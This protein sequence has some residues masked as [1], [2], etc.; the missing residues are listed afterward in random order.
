MKIRI[1]SCAKSS[2]EMR[3]SMNKKSSLILLSILHICV[4]GICVLTI[5]ANRDRASE[6]MVAHVSSDTEFIAPQTEASAETDP[7]AG[8]D[9]EPGTETDPDKG[10]DAGT[11]SEADSVTGTETDP[12][13]GSDPETE[14]APDADAGEDGEENSPLYSFHYTGKKANL[15]IRSAPS[16]EEMI[17]GKIPVGGNGSI[18]ELTNDKWALVEYQGIVGY[19][20]RD[21]LE[22]HEIEQ[23]PD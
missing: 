6:V 14:P 20:S 19:C 1:F 23:S 9:A 5:Y 4:L 17:I 16:L 7:G 3:K 21:Y 8:E 2:I 22:L 12:G 11:A 13:A 15:N 18:L 10:T